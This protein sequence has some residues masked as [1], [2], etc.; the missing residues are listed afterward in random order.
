M[1]NLDLWLYNT[2]G[3]QKL[4]KNL[5]K[6]SVSN[7][8]PLDGESSKLSLNEISYLLTAGSIFAHSSDGKFQDAALRI[9]QFCLV[10]SIDES[11]SDSAALIL[12]SLRNNATIRL[13]EQRNLLIPGFYDR[14]PNCAYIESTKRKL[15]NTIELSDESSVH[16]NKFQL[17]LWKAIES[18][19]WLSVSAPTS[20]GKSFILEVWIQEYLAK[21]TN[22]LVVFLVPTRALIS[23]VEKDIKSRLDS[24]RN[25]NVNIASL[26]LD[27]AYKTNKSN[28]LIFT[29]ERLHIFLNSFEVPPIID[30]L[31]VD[32]AH[33]IGGDYRG[34]FLQQVIEQTHLNNPLAQF[35]FASPFT[36]NPEV[37]LDNAP[38]QRSAFIKSS[39]VT[40]NQNLL[41]VSQMPRHLDEWKVQL[42]LE[43]E[44]INLGLIALP[45]KP[46]QISKRLPYVAL[47]MSNN[48]PGN[49]VYVNGAADAETAAWQIYECLTKIDKIDDEIKALIDLCDKTIH[50]NY[51]LNTTLTRGVAFHY[52]NMPLLVKSEIERLFSSNKIAFLVCTS[53]LVEGVNMSCRNIFVRGPKKG[54]TT[55]MNDEDF[56]NLA[57][58]AGRWG[59]EFQGNIICVDSNESDLW[60]NGSPPKTKLGVTIKRSTDKILEDV[61]TLSDYIRSP[62]HKEESNKRPDLE[63]ALSYLCI[64]T[65]RYGSLK[66]SPYFSNKNYLLVETLEILVAEVFDSIE[67]SKVLIERNPGVSPI[68][69][70]DLLNRF[71]TTAKDNPERFLL[72]E[73]GSNDA[74]ENYTAAFTRISATLS[75][76]LGFTSKQAFLRSLLVVRWMRGYPLA[77]L[78]QERISYLRSKNN[79]VK[80]TTVI[81]DVMKDVEE[82]ARY[83]APKLLSCYNDIL[84]F[85]YETIN[86]YDLIHK[87]EDISI[88]LEM[89]LNQETQLSLVEMG[90]SRTAAVMIS[91]LISN[92]NLKVED[93]L[94]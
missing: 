59:K 86:R 56:W 25:G 81:R 14:L 68:L 11:K 18:N 77:R 62:N 65:C 13:A 4:Y 64:T 38:T 87:I 76:K 6:E 5:C 16:V 43:N 26:P 17:K 45:V 2:D 66:I 36:T 23:Q 40:V 3:F 41:W 85:Y 12:D 44:V 8:F 7:Q 48:N 15:E 1:R 55:L 72:S 35:I 71:V 84:A 33:K 94:N 83:Q 80:E 39:D 88:Y 57:G 70:Q 51:L 75:S 28:V 54:P 91:E 42:C 60:L 52:G 58:R 93:C 20:A 53:T 92:D 19:L 27:R 78:I 24:D 30:V 47:A 22:K 9:A 31:I 34:I 67:F 74:V 73:P 21:H 46:H 61:N 69:M 82:V 37:L 89:G 63:H 29:Q 79:D 49:I 90:I 32:E 50:K 10:N